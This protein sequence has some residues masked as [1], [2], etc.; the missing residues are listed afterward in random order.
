MARRTHH[1]HPCDVG[2][3]LKFRPRRFQERQVGDV[4]GDR[5]IGAEPIDEADTVDHSAF[6]QAAL[7][8]AGMQF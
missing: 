4:L 8:D 1:R 6:D 3:R 7:I 2:E 5:G